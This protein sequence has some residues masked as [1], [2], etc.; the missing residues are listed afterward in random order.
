MVLRLLQVVLLVALS[1]AADTGDLPPVTWG[2]SPVEVI[3]EPHL[4]RGP[5]EVDE[6]VSVHLCTRPVLDHEAIVSLYFVDG[7]YAC[8]SVTMQTAGATTDQA[9]R[10]FD[11]VVDRLEATIGPCSERSGTTTGG[12][13]VTWTAN[14]E[15][16]RAVVDPSGTT[17]LIGI[18]AFPDGQRQRIARLLSW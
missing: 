13:V 17:T 11:E 1:A 9:Q 10:E 12:S 2:G 5:L 15:T 8:F 18:V 16:V 14:G 3:A 6:G 4:C 7:A